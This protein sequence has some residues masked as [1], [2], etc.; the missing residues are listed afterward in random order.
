MKEGRAEAWERAWQDWWSRHAIRAARE[1]G[2]F[3]DVVLRQSRNE[4]EVSW[5]NSRIQGMPIILIYKTKREFDDF[6]KAW[7]FMITLDDEET[8]RSGDSR[9]L[10]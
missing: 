4:I 2:L 8:R 3:P 1:G 10:D 5:G 7:N 9:V 6:E